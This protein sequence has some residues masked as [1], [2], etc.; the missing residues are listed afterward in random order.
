MSPEFHTG[1]YVLISSL[2]LMLG[3]VR[4]GS[5]LVFNT[6]KYGLLIKHVSRIDRET[7][8]IYFKGTNPLSLSEEEIGAINRKDILGSVIVHFKE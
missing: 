5:A 1:D 7:G 3:L 2:P 8:R 4:K 6:E